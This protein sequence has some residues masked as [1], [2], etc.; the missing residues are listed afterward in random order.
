MLSPLVVVALK[1]VQASL[2]SLIFGVLA[3]LT[4]ALVPLLRETK[5]AK[6][7][8]ASDA[9]VA[10]EFETEPLQQAGGGGSS[11]VGAENGVAGNEAAVKRRQSQA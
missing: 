8:A 5:E 7:N 3:A 10:S 2:P 1:E 4:A 11:V 6:S 9:A